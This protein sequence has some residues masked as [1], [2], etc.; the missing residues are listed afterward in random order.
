MTVQIKI[1]GIT[2]IEDAEYA[3]SSG[4]DIIGFNFYP[5][6]PRFI[7]LDRALELRQAIGSRCAVAGV[8]V[9]AARDYI[10]ER[11]DALRL[12]YLQ[13]HGDEDAAALRGWPVKIIRALRLKPDT[14]P[15]L[16]QS[17]GADYT[18]LDTFHPSLFGGTGVSRSLDGLNSHD[19]SRVLISGGL[20]VEN[21]AAA[22]RLNPF[23]IDVASGV[24]HTPGIKD[25][26]KLRSFIANAKRAG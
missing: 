22:V 15:E 2:R 10:A 18:L 20:T 12:D 19:L 26:V 23:G 24:E 11:V 5:P 9:N 8:F 3:A 7:S 17:D 14:P 21:V 4:A 16:P 1:C 13:F 6:S 25:P